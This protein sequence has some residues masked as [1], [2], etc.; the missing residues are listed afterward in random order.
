MKKQPEKT[1][2]IPKGEE[3]TKEVKSPSEQ[4]SKTR[5]DSD[6]SL[7]SI[8]YSL[9]T[10]P[11]V[12]LSDRF[13]FASDI[14]LPFQLEQALSSSFV[15]THKSEVKPYVRFKLADIASLKLSKKL[16]LNTQEDKSTT[17]DL[18]LFN[19]AILG[20][21]DY[22]GKDQYK[23]FWGVKLPKINTSNE[24]MIF[25]FLG[26]AK[27]DEE[28]ETSTIGFEFKS[29]FKPTSSKKPTVSVD[30]AVADVE[31]PLETWKAKLGIKSDLKNQSSFLLTCSVKPIMGGKDNKEITGGV[32]DAGATMTF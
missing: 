22:T 2:S 3:G 13:K 12:T 20:M 19:R 4:V 14:V 11:G 21:E 9:S 17:I 31:N 5:E 1:E 8:S 32:F 27:V 10:M 26:T 28:K 30:L 7:S 24:K 25:T 29:Q 15:L 6:S 18:N 16:V 23:M